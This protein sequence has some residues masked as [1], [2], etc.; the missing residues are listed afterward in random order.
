[1][2]LAIETARD[3][4]HQWRDIFDRPVVPVQGFL[5]HWSPW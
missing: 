1:M 5:Q 3:V 4:Y 2:T